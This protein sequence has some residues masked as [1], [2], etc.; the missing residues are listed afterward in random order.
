MK[1]TYISPNMTVYETVLEGLIATSLTERETG[2]VTIN[3]DA[4]DEGDF[5]DASRHNGTSSIW[6]DKW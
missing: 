5:T 1:K 4:V 6:D 2:T 3:G